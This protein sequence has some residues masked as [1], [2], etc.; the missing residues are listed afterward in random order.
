M[1][2]LMNLATPLSPIYSSAR[3]NLGSTTKV[4]DE[5]FF[6]SSKEIDVLNSQLTEKIDQ[7]S[8]NKYGFQYLISFTDGTH[9]EN[10]DLKVLKEALSS[11]PKKTEA[12]ILNWTLG[13]VH[14]GGAEDEINI[15][16]RLSNPGDPFA[17]IK[18]LMSSKDHLEMDKMKYQ[19]GTV[20]VS[21]NGATQILAEEFFAIVV[22]WAKSCP[23]PHS[24]TKINETISKNSGKIEFLNYWVFPILF[25]IV[26]YQYLLTAVGGQGYATL[27]A[28]ISCLILLRQAIQSFNEKLKSLCW[29]S[30]R[31]SLFIITS[32]DS[33]EQTRIASLS[34][35]SMFKLVGS[36]IVSFAVNIAAGI[37]LYHM[38]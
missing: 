27:F 35:N 18:A 23:Q 14:E 3:S 4:I 8:P 34:R 7:L 36:V 15:T 10:R 30:R 38:F 1:K 20:S 21:I 12:L 5:V 6:C 9:H 16:V 26:V 13:H 25:T 32:G 22:R 19:D 33:N 17:V 31:F 2:N 29:R 24:I 11:S 37:V 28:S